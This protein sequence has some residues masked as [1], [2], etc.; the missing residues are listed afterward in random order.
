MF[1]L[2]LLFFMIFVYLLCVCRFVCCCCCCCLH[3]YR[4]GKEE[5]GYMF[6]CVSWVF[7]GGWSGE[8]LGFLLLFWRVC[9][10]SCRPWKLNVGQAIFHGAEQ[11]SCHLDRIEI[12]LIDTKTNKNNN[13]TQ[14]V[15]IDSLIGVLVRHNVSQMLAVIPS[16]SVLMASWAGVFF[17]AF[18][19]LSTSGIT[20]TF[21]SG[22]LML[23]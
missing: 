21:S 18:N 10:R 11:V 22:F 6:L 3:H 14:S 4:V 19:P 16:S 23:Y 17:L 9:W 2:P 20:K 1:Y 15:S 7:V 12:Q 5:K 8:T 13:K